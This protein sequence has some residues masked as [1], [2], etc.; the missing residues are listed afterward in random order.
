MSGVL[1]FA[2]GRIVD[3]VAQSTF[4]YQSFE[5]IPVFNDLSAK[6]VEDYSLFN[7]YSVTTTFDAMRDG[8]VVFASPTTRSDD[9]NVRMS[10][11]T[12]WTPFHGASQPTF[13]PEPT[14]R[15]VSWLF[16]F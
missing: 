3:I 2:F 1:S 12:K 10:I 4:D 6:D 7:D 8:V 13:T 5:E 11:P 16:F 14:I 15:D 9:F